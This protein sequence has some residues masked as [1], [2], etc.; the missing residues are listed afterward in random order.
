MTKVI[1]KEGR[2]RSFIKIKK[3]KTACARYI[4]TQQGAE[5]YFPYPQHFTGISLGHQL[6]FWHLNSGHHLTETLQEAI[7]F[8]QLITQCTSSLIPPFPMYHLKHWVY[9]LPSLYHVTEPHFYWWL[10]LSCPKGPFSAFPFGKLYKKYWKGGERSV[11]NIY[12]AFT[13]RSCQVSLIP[14]KIK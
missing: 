5:M 7:S 14:F 9:E 11:G 1:E 4:T 3:Q 6:Y 10:S 13:C 12:H 2:N 8:P